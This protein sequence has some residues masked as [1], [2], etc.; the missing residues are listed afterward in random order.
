MAI[1]VIYVAKKQQTA[2]NAI[3]H[4]KQYIS[5]SEKDNFFNRK[6]P[7]GETDSR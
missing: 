6:K 7:P 1:K 4:S 5:N 3:P 2:L